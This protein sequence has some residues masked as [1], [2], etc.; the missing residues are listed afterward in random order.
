MTELTERNLLY[1]DLY[2]SIFSI[3][4]VLLMYTALKKEATHMKKNVT[5]DFLIQ[6][7]TVAPRE[8]WLIVL[9]SITN[10]SERSST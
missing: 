1:W 3:F 6:E 2:S 5:K 8:N 4:I 9:I 10:N 7:R